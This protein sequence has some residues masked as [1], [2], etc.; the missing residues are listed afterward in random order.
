[1]GITGILGVAAL[2]LGAADVVAVDNDPQALLASRDNAR[3]N[4][5]TDDQLKTYLPEQ[6]PLNCHADVVVANASVD[7]KLI[8]TRSP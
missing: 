6:L 2:L 3:R 8:M 5:I 7:N 4:Q 1:M